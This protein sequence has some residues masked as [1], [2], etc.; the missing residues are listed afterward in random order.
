[1]PKIFISYRREDTEGHTG[2]IYDH[3]EA[4]FGSDTVFMDVDSIPF[5]VDFRKHLSDAVN[6]CDILLVVIGD[7]W[8]DARAED[9]SRRLDS[10]QDFVRIEIEAALARDIPVVPVLVG[11]ATMPSESALP[12]SLKDLAYR[13]A[14]EVRAGR[15][16]RSQMERLIRGL[17]QLPPKELPPAEQPAQT[18]PTPSAKARRAS[19]ATTNKPTATHQTKPE[20]PVKPQP[21]APPAK[22]SPTSPAQPKSQP[23]L[24]IA[25]FDTATAKKHQAAWAK[26]LQTD[27]ILANSLG[28][29]LALVPP[30]EFL[31]GSSE[32]EK[33]RFDREGPQHRV[34][35]TQPLYLGVCPVTQAEYQQL[36]GKNPSRFKGDGRLPAEQVT[37][38]AANEFCQQ[39]SAL[40]EEQQKGWT[41][42]LPTEAEWEYACRAFT[43]TRFCFGDDDSQLAAYAWHSAN[44]GT[45]THPV[46]E[47]QPNA[48]GLCDMHGNVW[49]WCADWFG[50][51]SSDPTE[52][53][54]GPT[55][56]SLR[57]LRGGCW[58]SPTRYCRS[59]VR[60]GVD[61]S[62]RI[63][64]L[65]F[66]L[67]LVPSSKQGSQR[68][69]EAIGSRAGL[70]SRPK[71]L[72]AKEL[73]PKSH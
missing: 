18:K 33:G 27:V 50:E 8:L 62:V 28:M 70:W 45:K 59:A 23:P 1:M 42:R 34:T 9:G 10:S 72:L 25:P 37:W 51:Y 67:A 65:G 3:L 46:G 40:A 20:T 35:I 31:M 56:G 14:A 11:R 61:P 49:E 30:G 4:K 44:S 55:R 52:D 15:N 6:D 17:E 68:T 26:H 58:G 7:R 48:W 57:V 66:R 47:K 39:L 12:T 36:T 54:T 32:T 60:D 64:A 19:E 29:Q 22:P 43:T 71:P 2:R 63:V 53:P 41:Y 69:G 13:N 24:A 73:G 38:P 5:G 21:K 16:F